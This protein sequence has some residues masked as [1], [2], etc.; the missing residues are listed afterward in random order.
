MAFR[1]FPATAAD[2]ESYVVIEFKDDQ[3]GSVASGEATAP[4]YELADGR[5]L[6]RHGRELITAGGELTLSIG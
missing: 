1:Q 5:K 4:R 6:I 3:N 2:G